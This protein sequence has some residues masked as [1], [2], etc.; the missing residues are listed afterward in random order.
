MFGHLPEL[1]IILG[2]GL[3][4]VIRSGGPLLPANNDTCGG[5]DP[6]EGDGFR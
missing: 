2:V 5:A 3:D 1:I 6:R 4:G